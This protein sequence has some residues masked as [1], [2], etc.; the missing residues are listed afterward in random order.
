MKNSE[1][2]KLIIDLLKFTTDKSDCLDSDSAYKIGKCYFI[3]TITFHVTGEL[4]SIYPHELVLKNAA[5]IA[6][7]GRFHDALKTGEFSEIEPFIEN[8]IINRDSIVDCTEW[9]HPL[10]REQ[11]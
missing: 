5:W 7:S 6:D 1:N 8:V 2:L 11:K 9:K 3:R 10:P 4:I